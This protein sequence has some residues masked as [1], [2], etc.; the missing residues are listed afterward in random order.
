MK[1]NEILTEGG[2]GSLAPAV[3]RAMPTTW[4]LPGLTNQDP[5]LQYR[6]GIA[7]ANARSGEPLETASAFGENM[8]VIGYTDADNETVKL[9]LKQMGSQYAKGAKSI[10]TRKSEEAVD[11]NKSSPV[12]PK[13]RNKYGI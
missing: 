4:E 1:I 2:T 12:P 13:K 11:V 10:A 6:M 3:A 8:T 7:M 9:A 5:Y